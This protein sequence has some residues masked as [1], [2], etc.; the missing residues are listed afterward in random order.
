MSEPARTAAFNTAF[1]IAL[2]DELFRLGVR[3]CCIAPG[4]RSGPLVAAIARHPGLRTLVITDERSA[5]FVALGVGRAT[6]AP[7]ALITT[8]GSAIGHALPAVLEAEADGVPLLLLSA[9]RPP[10]LRG[11]GANQTLDQVGLFGCHVRAFADLP[12][13]DDGTPLAALLATVDHAVARALSP[14]PG[15][16][17]LNLMLREPLAPVAQG[18]EWLR[19]FAPELGAWHGHGR[20]FTRWSPTPPAP[21]A[22]T[23][24]ALHGALAQARRGLLVVGG[25]RDDEE[26]E[27]VRWLAAW[28]GW[29]V[30]ADITSGLRSDDGLPG[31]VPLYDQLLLSERFAARH[32][33]GVV[34]Q[35]GGRMVSKRWLRALATRPPAE[36][37]VVAAGPGRGDPAHS[38]TLRLPCSVKALTAALVARGDAAM[39]RPGA[40]AA[41]GRQ[42]L[43]EA[44]AML[45]REVEAALAR[46]PT[47][48]EIGVARAVAAHLPAGHLLFAASSMPIRDLDM[49]A[50]GRG[51]TRTVHA[52]RGASG[53][54]GLVATALGC[55]LGAGRP[56]ALLV[57]DQAL[58]HDIG[59]L[60]VLA[61]TQAPLTTV[62]VDNGGG[63]IFDFLDLGEDRDLRERCF[64]AA[65]DTDFA[66]LCT[67]FGVE[68][69]RVDT[70][71]ALG[72][73]L[74]RPAAAG[75]LVIEV[76]TDRARN[77][78]EHRQLQALLATRLDALAD[79]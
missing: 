30:F 35:V 32:S 21:D 78:A 60:S 5:A 13:P 41:A 38:A 45:E 12:C 10:E 18:P 70:E 1:G 42:A 39:P 48:G 2:A 15:P 22:A 36:H 40:S 7:A 63:G 46:A 79:S 59:S 73:A 75:P 58:L 20:P 57:G 43:V 54:D 14:H 76:R 31:L 44:S 8:S 69:R 68:H 61:A 53:I 6:G 19:A 33:P 65:H 37:I 23:L 29:P 17:H 26:R 49:Y 50:P 11:S 66:R 72:A 62:L 74:Q 67:G 28:L 52:N 56:G 71:E 77:V 27:A 34:L 16:V 64:V 3:V 9:D 47:L 4:A 25:L 24:S 55:V 51:G